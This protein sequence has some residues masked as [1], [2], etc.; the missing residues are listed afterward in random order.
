[1]TIYCLWASSFILF[2]HLS[3]RSPLLSHHIQVVVEGFC[4]DH[5]G[6]FGE[7]DVLHLESKS[8]IRRLQRRQETGREDLRVDPTRQSLPVIRLQITSKGGDEG[9]VGGSSGKGAGGKGQGKDEGGGE[10]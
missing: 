6:V 2:Y 9:E 7:I 10:R 4:V 3:A 8:A 5:G 1:M